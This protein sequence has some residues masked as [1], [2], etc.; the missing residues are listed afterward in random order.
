[1]AHQNTFLFYDLETFGLDPQ[2]DRVAQFAAVRTD[3]ELKVIDKPIVLYCRLSDDYLPDPLAILI[4]HITPDE[5]NT[6]GMPEREF[7][8]EINRHFSVENT[9][10]LG[11]NSL[12]F[13]DEFIR[14]GLFRNFIDPYAREYAHGNSRF[15]ILDLVR[16]THDFR[17]EGIHWPI[18]PTTGFPSFSLT[19]LT[20]A[21]NISHEDAHDA[22]S[23]VMATLE[24][25][26]LIREK[27]PKLFNY[28]LQMRSKQYVRSL[29]PTPLG[30]PVTLT[31]RAFISEDGATRIITPITALSA[32][33][34]TIIAF[35]LTQ[36]PGELIENIGA[37]DSLYRAVSQRDEIQKAMQNIR[38]ATEGSAD[39]KAALE[40]AMKALDQALQAID[41]LPEKLVQSSTLLDSKG[42][43]KVA[44][45]KVPL[46][47]PL[48]MLTKE[49]EI[50]KRLGIDIEKALG[51]YEELKDCDNLTLHLLRAGNNQ[52]FKSIDDV[53]HSLYSGNFLSVQ[54]QE[55]SELIRGM[56]GKDLLSHS[57]RFD[58]PRLHEMLWRYLCRNHSD[59][60]DDAERE[61]WHSFCAQRIMNPLGKHSI[62][63]SFFLR[64]ISDHLESR[65][66][67]DE[68]KEM[69]K[70]LR[71]YGERLFKR[72]GL[73]I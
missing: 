15:D 7:F 28:F 20:E 30:E 44:I 52:T 43:I 66:I 63:T 45:N 36:D 57:P 68:D 31:S 58:D 50:A 73:S 19:S 65:E 11:F 17:P 25:T 5:V 60:L 70:E 39:P 54:D 26:R 53:D 32:I 69:L 16:A 56:S 47:A 61:K 51:H 22:L 4:T 10:V 29:L 14:F 27:Q 13:D 48:S 34:N 72:I 62:D 33:P 37:H 71:T 67:S 18:N 41:S 24:V 35:D 59:L 46:I 12:R 1:M 2:H 49:R 42:I 38:L 8:L 23:D 21:N 40:L 55:R 9:C 64:K 6:K 3:T